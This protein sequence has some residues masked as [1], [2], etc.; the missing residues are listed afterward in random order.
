MYS[1]PFRF[2]AAEARIVARWE[3]GVRNYPAPLT[4]A[5]LA[6]ILGIELFRLRQHTP[7]RPAAMLF[8]YAAALLLYA[9]LLFYLRTRVNATAREIAKRELAAD[10]SEDGDGLAVVEYG[11]K[12]VF[13]A[14]DADVERV[15]AG[16]HVVRICAKGG[17]ICLPRTQVP[18]DYLARML[19]QLGTKNYRVRG[20]M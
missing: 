12:T 16:E 4:A 18:D 8:C 19:G 15:D 2:T 11:D 9:A 10:F 5:L 6:A 3:I 13:R 14:P 1:K 20:W 17:T 7:A